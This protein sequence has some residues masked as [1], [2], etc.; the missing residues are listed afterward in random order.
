MGNKTPNS[1]NKKSRLLFETNPIT[2]SDLSND[3]AKSNKKELTN[4]T[5]LEK[6]QLKSDLDQKKSHKLSTFRES[7]KRNKKKNVNFRVFLYFN[8]FFII[9]KSFD[10][11]LQEMSESVDF[12]KDYCNIQELHNVLKNFEKKL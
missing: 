5:E 9:K 6:S 8:S 2:N 7:F 1:R 12:I 11:A 3:I 4:I 10:I